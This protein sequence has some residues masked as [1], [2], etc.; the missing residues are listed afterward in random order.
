MAVLSLRVD[1]FITY[2]TPCLRNGKQ[3]ELGWLK[4]RERE[5]RRRKRAGRGNRLSQGSLFL[6]QAVRDR[7][8]ELQEEA[9]KV[10][11]ATSSTLDTTLQ[12]LA[13]NLNDLAHEGA[14]STHTTP[15]L[16]PAIPYL[17]FLRQPS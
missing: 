11:T 16:P 14:T 1:P 9:G 5:S 3:C 12:L 4:T 7:K 8:R 2:G 13:L 17:Q 15:K 6:T 10:P